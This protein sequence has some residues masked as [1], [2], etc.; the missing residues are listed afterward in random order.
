MNLS[1]L[2]KNRIGRLEPI[3]AI[4]GSASNGG[5]WNK[6]AHEQAKYRMVITPTLQGYGRED[7]RGFN[8][9][10]TLE[11]RARPLINSISQMEQ[12][13][14]LVAHSFGA[15]VALQIV[16]V[17]PNRISSV[18]FYE[19]V[20]PALLRDTGEARDLELLG[21]LVALSEILR[22]SASKVGM[23]TFINFWSGADTWG[24][25][26][27]QAQAKLS[28]LAPIVYQD[29]VEAYIN[30]LPNMFKAIAYSGPLK[31]ILGAE[32]NDHA[33]RMASI[34][35]SQFPQTYIET[36][37]HMGHMGPLTHPNEVHSSIMNHVARIDANSVAEKAGIQAC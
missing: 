37:A 17:I 3:V 14:H 29:F 5:L 24:N 36:L 22:G 7:V 33:R 10:S 25:L 27:E 4:H 23:E 28:E 31:L 8:L 2:A 1:S 13:V 16:R 19:P 18:T 21:D 35:L 34:L 26:P 9:S 30:I 6:L 32:T 20:A 11:T 12:K 15:S